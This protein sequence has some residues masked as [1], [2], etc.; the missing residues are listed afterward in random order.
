M[1]KHVA[2][3]LYGIGVR[4]DNQPDLLFS[5]RQVDAKDLVTQAGAGLPKNKKAPASTKVL[6]ASLLA[7]V[8]G[9]EMAE[10]SPPVVR[11]KLPA[12]KE[13]LPAAKKTPSIKRPTIA[14]KAAASKKPVSIKKSAM[15]KKTVS[16]R[17]LTGTRTGID[18][19]TPKRKPAEPKRK[20]IS[21]K[22]K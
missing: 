2:A 9:I 11:G 12:A 22:K 10:A 14:Q 8:F 6:D 5:L 19:A 16:T 13:K 20:P 3:V 15:I 1:C 4:L 21:V 18:T 17:K 7:D